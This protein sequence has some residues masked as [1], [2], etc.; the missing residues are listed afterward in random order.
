M[1]TQKAISLK[2]NTKT[3]EDL[4]REASLGWA[5]RNWHINQ[6]VM[7]YLKVLDDRRR[8]HCMG[9]RE[10]KLKAMQD[11]LAELVPESRSILLQ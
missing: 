8:I 4:D 2:L 11:L 10:D 1:I 9:S 6:A 7:M 5:K 3:L